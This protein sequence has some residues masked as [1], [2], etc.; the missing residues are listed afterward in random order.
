MRRIKN[1]IINIISAMFSSAYFTIIFFTL[2]IITVAYAFEK[3]VEYFDTKKE[4]R[5]S[6]KKRKEQEK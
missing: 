6:W 4:K 5:K 3:I 1:L 2:V